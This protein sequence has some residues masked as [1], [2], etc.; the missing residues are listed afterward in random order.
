MTNNNET[1]Q[2]MYEVYGENI[3]KYLTELTR[4]ISNG[5]G[6]KE[7]PDFQLGVLSARNAVAVYNHDNNIIVF[8]LLK[9]YGTE[10]EIDKVLCSLAHEC[11]HAWQWN[12][13]PEISEFF[14]KNADLYFDSY[15]S[16]FN[17]IEADAYTIEFSYGRKSLRKMFEC[18]D[19]DFFT[20]HSSNWQTVASSMQERYQ[21]LFDKDE[22]S[23][24]HGLYR[25]LSESKT[26]LDFALSAFHEEI[27]LFS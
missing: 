16:A 7:S 15:D 5:M 20:S 11:E 18:Y 25:L 17:L 22:Q 9:L 24:L 3:N 14:A 23:N 12:Y 8:D 26:A 6:V 1:R 19:I 4:T 27:S 10:N 21:E 13:Y 2:I